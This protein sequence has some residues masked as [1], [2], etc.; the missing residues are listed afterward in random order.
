MSESVRDPGQGVA[1]KP[2][3]EL[4]RPQRYMVLLHNDHY[5]TMDFVVEVLLSIFRKAQD[6]AEE[7]MLSVHKKG[8][9]VAG[10][11][12][13]AVAETKVATVHSLAE[14]RGFPLRCSVEPE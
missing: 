7:I 6:E 5:T 1:I 4:K 12:T 11:Y 9:G 8:Q 2:R 10:L 13:A 14:E 3:H